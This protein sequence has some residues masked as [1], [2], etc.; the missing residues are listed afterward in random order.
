MKTRKE[1][2][3]I[4]SNNLGRIKVEYGVDKIGVFGS[5]VRSEQTDISDIDILVEFSKA[6]GMIKFLKLEKTLQELLGAKVDLVT[7]NA[8]KKHIGQQILD[9]IQYVQ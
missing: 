1:V 2:F 5:V 3:E 7:R 9:E 4:L 8:L 6:T